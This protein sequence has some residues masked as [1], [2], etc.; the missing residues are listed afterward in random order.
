MF[1]V[2]YPDTT[3]A[4]VKHKKQGSCKNLTYPI[5]SDKNLQ[6]G[7]D[8]V[9]RLNFETFV[10]KCTGEEKTEYLHNFASRVDHF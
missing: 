7:A 2:I 4:S 8:F 3:T 9:N 5:L 10:Y 6:Q 1:Q